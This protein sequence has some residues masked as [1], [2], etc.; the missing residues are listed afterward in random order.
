MNPPVLLYFSEGH[1]SSDSEDV[2]DMK[3]EHGLQQAQQNCSIKSQ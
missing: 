1:D 2:P 3:R